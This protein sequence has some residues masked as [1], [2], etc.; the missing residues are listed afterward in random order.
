VHKLGPLAVA[1]C[2]LPV[3]GPPMSTTLWDAGIEEA[4]GGFSGVSRA[5]MKYS[6][7]ESK[8]EGIHPFVF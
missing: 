2:V 1:R 8:A 4:G 3:S 6:I 5:G 7:I